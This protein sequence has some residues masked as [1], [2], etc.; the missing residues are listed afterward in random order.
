MPATL[1]LDKRHGGGRGPLVPPGRGGDGGPGSPNDAPD[2]RERLNRYRLGM[3]IGLVGIIMVFVG[4]TSAYIVRQGATTIDPDTG[5]A[6]ADWRPITLPVGTLALNTLLLVGSSVA[7]ELAR[8]SLKRQY[9]VAAAVGEAQAQA[10]MP[11][12]AVS[13]LLGVG[14]LMGQFLVWGQLRARGVYLPTNPS[15]SFFYLLTALHGVHL[16]GGMVALGYAQ[17][18]AWLHRSL[19]RRLLVVDVT[20]IYW[21]FMA[22][23]WLYIFALFQFVR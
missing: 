17:A 22:L 20:S 16:L 11:W 15:S 4:L 23:L 21:H 18:T 6:S 12:L 13:V 9:A 19:A 5:I 10:P 8:R 3:A 1:E 14:F 7:L 2:F